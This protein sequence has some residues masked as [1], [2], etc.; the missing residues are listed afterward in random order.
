MSSYK[1]L[2][3]NVGLFTISEFASKFITFFMLPLY[4]YY[5]STE[6]YAVIDLIQVTQNLI[7]PIVTLS[8]TDAVLCF[9]FDKNEKID[10]VFTIGVIITIGASALVVT[11]CLITSRNEIIG[12]YLWGIICSMI[13]MMFSNLLFNFARAVDKVQAITISSIITTAIVASSNVLMVAYWKMGVAGYLSALVL[14]NTFKSIYLLISCRAWRYCNF[15]AC[16]K[17]TLVRMLRYSLPLIPNGL[18]WWVNSSINKYF[19]TGM[20]TLA[21]VGLYSA[22]SKIP[23]MGNTIANV[24]NSAWRM[25]AIKEVDSEDKNSF[26]EMI[27]ELYT[28]TLAVIVLGITVSVK[29]LALIL[30]SKDFYDAWIVVPFLMLGFYFDS[31]NAFIGNLFVGAKITKVLFTTTVV[32]AVANVALNAA[33]IPPFGIVGAAIATTFSNTV[34]FFVRRKRAKEWLQFS[35]SLKKQGPVVAAMVILALAA[36]SNTIWL[37]ILFPFTMAVVLFIYRQQVGFL[38]QQGMKILGKVKK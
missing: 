29:L 10:D 2:L 12:Q 4:T 11:G 37:Y 38:Y 31:I 15:R 34:I 35:P 3:K 20:T 19:L 32:G 24:F 8:I 17:D 23:A 26:F 21:Q 6:E 13:S 7:V 33:L 14:G 16:H 1:Y 22:A 36:F 18:F 5:L 9:C 28:F 27:Y 30:F 25:S